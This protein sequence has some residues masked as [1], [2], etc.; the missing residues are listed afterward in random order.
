MSI[1]VILSLAVSIG[2]V[3]E[4][5]RKCNQKRKLF[6][7]QLRFERR[8]HTSQRRMKGNGDSYCYNV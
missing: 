6:A 4:T 3:T 8:R 5:M 7:M 2:T 1:I